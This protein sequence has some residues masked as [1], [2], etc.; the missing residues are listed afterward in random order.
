MSSETVMS[1]KIGRNHG[2]FAALPPI[3]TPTKSDATCRNDLSFLLA[4]F[5]HSNGSLRATLSP[6]TSLVSNIVCLLPA[7]GPFPRIEN[8]ARSCHPGSRAA[9]VSPSARLANSRPMAHSKGNI[10]QQV[11]RGE[12]QRGSHA[13][14]YCSGHCMG[15]T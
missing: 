2:I 15:H 3:T 6:E 10:R 11:A 8:P 5:A 9:T 1:A 13:W 12:V 7:P 4:H 14:R